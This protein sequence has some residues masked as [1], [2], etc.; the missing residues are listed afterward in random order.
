MKP[1]RAEV[2]FFI[3]GSTGRAFPPKGKIY[4]ALARILGDP[5]P[6]NGWTIELAFETY[7][8]FTRSCLVRFH[9]PKAPEE[10]LL[11]NRRFDLFEGRHL[12]GRGALTPEVRATKGQTSP[13]VASNQVSGESRLKTDRLD[14]QEQRERRPPTWLFSG[15]PRP[16]ISPGNH[17]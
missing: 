2:Q 14:M 8:G 16:D 17:A 11:R 1:Q 5:Q 15:Q 6:E 12:V 7:S 9:S 3:G 10:L 4:V 13:F